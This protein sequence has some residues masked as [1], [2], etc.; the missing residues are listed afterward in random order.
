VG[1]ST[2]LAGSLADLAE[3]YQA[4]HPYVLIDVRATDSAT[5]LRALSAGETDVAAVSWQEL[6]PGTEAGFAGVPVAEDGLALIAHPGNRVR[7]LTLLQVKAL[8]QGEILNWAALAGPD[9]EPIIVSREDGSGT[10][11]AFESLVMGGERVTLN[12]LIMPGS[13]AVVDYVAGHPA[14]VGYVTAAEADGRVT[15]LRV[16]DAA[17]T[18]A[19]VRAGSYHLARLLFLYRSPS[20]PPVAQNFIEFALSPAGQAII[21]RR[22][23]P[24]R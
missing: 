7:S 2:S 20:S 15:V 9:A 11:A 19:E 17:P 12:A 16:E 13:K 22:H 21:G 1:G 23:V 5:G 8:Y 14:A 24:V 18:P 4:A 10:R 6:K 3:A